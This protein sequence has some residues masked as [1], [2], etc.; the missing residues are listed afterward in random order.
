MKNL[1]KDISMQEIT[2]KNKINLV[3][4]LML[5]F[6]YISCNRAT[7]NYQKENT[8]LK[9]SSYV[10]IPYKSTF[11]IPNMEKVKALNQS[12]L[13][14]DTVEIEQILSDYFYHYSRS[15]IEVG[16]SLVAYDIND[17]GMNKYIKQLVPIIGEKGEEYI[18]VN[19]FLKENV[20]ALPNWKKQIVSVSDGGA[21]FFNIFINL[22]TK[23]CFQLSVN[24]V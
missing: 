12:D 1:E 11:D 3:V 15:K 18:W 7:T 6:M 13:H 21:A 17:I 14:I 9:E 20:K 8:T 2:I 22:K 24:G 10:F 4:I 16:K 23:T 5:I 19:C